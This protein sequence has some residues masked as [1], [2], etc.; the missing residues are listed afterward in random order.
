[1]ITRKLLVKVFDHKLLGTH[2]CRLR[3]RWLSGRARLWPP[4]ISQQAPRSRCRGSSEWSPQTYHP[5]WSHESGYLSHLGTQI[6]VKCQRIQTK[7]GNHL[8]EKPKTTVWKMPWTALLQQYIKTNTFKWE[9]EALTVNFSSID[10]GGIK[11]NFFS[12]NLH[13]QILGKQ[14]GIPLHS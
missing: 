10:M 2:V 9:W 7:S 5:Q 12:W 11:W 14:V 8:S 6:I 13:L 4:G 1:M 3:D